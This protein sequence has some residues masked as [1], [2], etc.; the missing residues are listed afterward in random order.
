MENLLQRFANPAADAVSLLMELAAL[1]RPPKHAGGQHAVDMLA[2]LRD[3]LA[4]NALHRRHLRR[5][6]L[7]LLGSKKQVP[8]YVETGI[9]PGT[10]FFSELWRRVTHSV[11]PDVIDPDSLKDV[12]G[13]IFNRPSDQV[14]M[15]SVPVED[16]AELIGAL[17]FDE[18]ADRT[19]LDK[20]LEQMLD[21]AQVI[22]YR[23]SSLGLEPEILRNEPSIEEF[24]SPFLMQNVEARH[25]F[26]H[27]LAWRHDPA[28]KPEDEKHVLV[29]LDQ[30]REILEKIRRNAAQSGTSIS[31]TFLTRRLK[32]NIRRMETLLLLLGDNLRGEPVRLRAGQLFSELARAEN[33]KNN[34]PSHVL[35]NINLLALRITDN[36][37][38][39][40]EHYITR[41]KEEYLAL[42]KSAAGAGFIV[43]FM[44][45]L[46][47]DIAKLHLP[48]LTEAILFCLNYGIGFVL[49]HMLHFTVA[50]KQPAMTAATIA[51]TIEESDGKEKHLEK[52][53]QLVVDT[54]RSQFIA[55]IGNM[56]LAF[57]ISLAI[58]WAIHALTGKHFVGPEKID[59]M[60]TEINPFAGLAIFYAAVAGVCLFLAGLIA[61][62]YD[63]KGAYN[64][65]PERLAH[66]R[67]LRKLFGDSGTARVAK[68]IENN[69][70]ALAGNFYFG[71]LLGSMSALGLLLGLPLD[72]RH[73]TFSTANFAYA[74]VGLDFAIDWKTVIISVIG[75]GA[76]GVTNLL[77]SFALALLVALRARGVSFAQERQLVG[78][79]VKLFFS[80]PLQFFLPLPLPAPVAEAGGSK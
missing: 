22:S 17:R 2:A 14:W 66:L 4:Q 60:L 61:G 27:Y 56:A 28:E 53:T 49:I 32:Q 39:T 54:M 80:S 43:A 52:L 63:N 12:L 65:I 8:L 21:A 7:T 30:C 76:I 67:W 11:L 73:I 50:T 26:E 36:A 42:F 1:I 44:A 79:V 47:I 72:I 38:K 13:L 10:G 77:V 58:G 41:N 25:F 62:Y 19:A 71:I 18:E 78:R 69:L 68:Y 3:C 35:R 16:W 33:E 37:S 64:R 40:G 34:V 5:A 74:V 46:K 24:E 75:I 51:E 70:G 31:L 59:K 55:I 9:L 45:M 15:E 57:P 29:L 48:Q 23:I 20:T 6:L